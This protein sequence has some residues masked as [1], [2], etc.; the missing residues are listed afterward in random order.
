MNLKFERNKL[1][2]EIQR[3][4][5]TYEFYRPKYNDYGEPIEDGKVL[6]TTLRAIYH[7]KNEYI[8]VTIADAAQYRTKKVPMLLCLYEECEVKID[9]EVEING[10]KHRVT[11]IVNIQEWNIIADI[12]LEVI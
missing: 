1:E 12:S 9:D 6:A 11:G 8:K 3:T 5:T 2:K 10:V 7:E 4:K